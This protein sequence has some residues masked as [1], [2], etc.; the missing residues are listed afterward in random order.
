VKKKIAM[1]RAGR[2]PTAFDM[3]TKI[4]WHM[5]LARRNDVPAQ[6][7]SVVEPCKSIAIVYENGSER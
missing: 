2:R 3:D 4:G 5:A 6:N 7:V 1:R